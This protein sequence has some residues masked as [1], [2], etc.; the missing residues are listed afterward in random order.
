MVKYL[1]VDLEKES[2][3]VC[4]FLQILILDASHAN[5][6]TLS[7]Q[8]ANKPN[9]LQNAN[10]LCPP[11]GNCFIKCSEFEGCRGL[12]INAMD[13][14]LLQIEAINGGESVL[15]DANITCPSKYKNI[16]TKKNTCFINVIAQ[17]DNDQYQIENMVIYSV[18]S[19]NNLNISCTDDH[20]IDSNDRISNNSVSELEN[21]CFD[22]NGNP[23][24]YCTEN[25]SDHCKIRY[26]IDKSKWECTFSSNLCND[27]YIHPITTLLINVCYIY[28]HVY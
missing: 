24:L 12:T 23:K 3:F 11:N 9:I 20:I 10:V 13:S 19:F 8:A 14:D 18:N 28:F 6:G 1:Y 27:Y 7:I 26:N 22:L 21:N 25:F 4:L 5:R 2:N 15:K 17:S 16:I